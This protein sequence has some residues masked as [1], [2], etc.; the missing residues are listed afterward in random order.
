MLKLEIHRG[1]TRQFSIAFTRNGAAL[2][3]TSYTA[4]FA[5]TATYETPGAAPIRKS[6]PASGI[7]IN[8][9]AG[10]LAT[11]TID[12]ADTGTV[13]N[14]KRTVWVCDL[15]LDAGGVKTDVDTGELI[16]LGSV[17]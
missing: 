17:D 16:I 8:D 13:A 7:A 10:G 2:D 4:H 15:Y 5:A 3:L 12:A 6:S 14:A 9:A 1:R 11:L